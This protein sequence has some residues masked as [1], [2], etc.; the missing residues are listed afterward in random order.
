MFQISKTSARQATLKE[1]KSGGRREWQINIINIPILNRPEGK[2][3]NL[4]D[5]EY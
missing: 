4:R 3:N 5:Y 1:R 2:G